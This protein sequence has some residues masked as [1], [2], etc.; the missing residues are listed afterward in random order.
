MMFTKAPMPE[1]SRQHLPDLPARLADYQMIGSPIKADAVAIP[2]TI[3][4]QRRPR[5]IRGRRYAPA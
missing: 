3:Q 4:G 5:C 1:A 2:H